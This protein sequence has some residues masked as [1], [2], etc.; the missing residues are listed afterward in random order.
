MS[1]DKF[2]QNYENNVKK[3]RKHFLKDKDS[4]KINRT[5]IS[6]LISL[7]PILLSLLTLLLFSYNFIILIVALILLIASSTIIALLKKNFNLEEN[8][9]LFEI[10]KQG[11]FSVKAYENKLYKLVFSDKGY[12]K[13]I[14]QDLI[15]E[16]KITKD[17][18]Y[19]IE[20]LRKNTYLVYNNEEK[21]EILIINDN[22]KDT[23]K[24]NRI[25]LEHIRYYR[26]DAIN[27][28]VILKTDNDELYYTPKSKEVFDAIFPKKEINE[29]EE[30]NPKLYINDFE[31]FMNR[32]K[33]KENDKK[34]KALSLK[35]KYLKVINTLV[36]LEIMFIIL[37]Y[38]Y[39]DFSLPINIIYTVVLVALSIYLYLFYSIKNIYI[40]NDKEYI[41][42]LN[43]D[44][45]NQDRFK[46]LKLAL[47]IPDKVEKIYSDEGAE[48]L[49][50]NNAGYFHLF[51]NLIYFNTIYIVV[52]ITDIEYYK[53]EK[54]YCELKLKDN[55]F[56]FEE[57]SIKVLAKLLPNKD[58]DW[59]KG[60]IK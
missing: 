59:I 6:F 41:E 42:Y 54:D 4:N 1:N 28:R 17:K 53:K 47:K 52:K 12:Y 32:I 43:S 10:R 50:W 37:A 11:F 34:E 31:R 3:A 22:L 38:I 39:K 20:D 58:Y 44:K 23:P 26:D 45:D 8:E 57:N 14:M 19:F 48:F 16:Y 7:I 55:T 56:K 15:N 5:N 24:V 60:I 46:E 21:Q 36:L 27:N 40:K 49:V 35:N 29:I 18:A 33:R 2:I 25:A 13:E 9:Y 51:L 30:Y